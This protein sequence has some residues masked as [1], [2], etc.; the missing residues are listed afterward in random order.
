MQ[1]DHR[2]TKNTEFA[3]VDAAADIPDSV[4]EELAMLHARLETLESGFGDMIKAA[5]AKASK[6]A[7]AVKSAV[8]KAT[9]HVSPLDKLKHLLESK[10]IIFASDSTSVMISHGNNTFRIESDGVDTLKVS[11]A[12]ITKEHL[13]PQDAL[14]VIQGR[15]LAAI[16]AP[17]SLVRG[18]PSMR[19]VPSA[20][21]LQYTTAIVQ[22][23]QR[24]AF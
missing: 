20:A 24:S 18:P 23:Q 22:Q 3:R 2:G 21:L 12:D 8:H 1:R 16:F 13:S 11:Y 5:K 10:K 6:A 9:A 7:N 4:V 14:D 19:L 15:N 17:P